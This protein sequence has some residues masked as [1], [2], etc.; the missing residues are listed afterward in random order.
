MGPP[1]PPAA[2]AM[3]G[4]TPHPPEPSPITATI[5]EM[6]RMP[7]METKTILVEEKVK[8]KCRMSVA[9]INNNIIIINNNKI[10]NNNVIIVVTLSQ[11][12]LHDDNHAA[13]IR[14]TGNQRIFQRSF[15]ELGEG[16]NS[17]QHKFYGIRY[18][19]GFDRNRERKGEEATIDSIGDKAT[20]Y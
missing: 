19:T 17:I 9:R 12:T 1:P 11:T 10:D 8:L 7:R 5:L 3:A 6:D 16:T 13:S 20:S 4:R 15:Y 2:T 14:R 18:D